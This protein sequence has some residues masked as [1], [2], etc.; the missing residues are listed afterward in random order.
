[1]FFLNRMKKDLTNISLSVKQ[2]IICST[3][4]K[5]K[6]QIYRGEYYKN[7]RLPKSLFSL[8]HEFYSRRSAFLWVLIV[9]ISSPFYFSLNWVSC[10][11]QKKVSRNILLQ[12]PLY[13]LCSSNDARFGDYQQLIYPNELKVED[14]TDTPKSA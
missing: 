10:H 1:M 2:N 9:L 12:L 8:V 4:H 3:E 7:L 5:N 11:K 6:K 14:T 13:R